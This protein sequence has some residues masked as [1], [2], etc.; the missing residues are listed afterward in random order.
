MVTME[1]LLVRLPVLRESYAYPPGRLVPDNDNCEDVVI[2]GEVRLKMDVPTTAQ[3]QQ[4]SVR[5]RYSSVAVDRYH[6]QL[7]L[8]DHAGERLHGLLSVIAWGYVSGTDSRIRSGRAMG[9]TRIVIQGAGAKIPQELPFIDQQLDQAR[10]AAQAGD[11]AAALAAAASI[12]FLGLSFASKLV[13]KMRPDIAVVLDSVINERFLDRAI[14]ALANFHGSMASTSKIGM[15]R[16]QKRYTD[17]CN[18][19]RDLAAE[20]NARQS[21]WRD[22]DGSTQ[23]WRAVDVERAFFAMA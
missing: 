23:Q 20:L 2:V 6:A 8:S 15:R 22:W 1:E 14:P 18:W 13:M 5:S 21:T 3:W 12:K 4:E 10:Q 17:W 16:N 7:L 19:C 9:K 11:L